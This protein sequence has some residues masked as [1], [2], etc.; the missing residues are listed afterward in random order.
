MGDLIQSTPLIASLRNKYPESRLTLIVSSDFEKFAP[1][2]PHIDEILLFNLKFFAN[3]IKEPITT[4]IPKLV[5]TKITNGPR[6]VN[7]K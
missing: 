5:K 7:P 3:P 2:I 1:R 4:P 6:Q